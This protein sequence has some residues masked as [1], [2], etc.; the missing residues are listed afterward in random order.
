MF[1]EWT[2]RE[3]MKKYTGNED[4]HLHENGKLMY[5]TTS[6]LSHY[7][8]DLSLDDNTDE[9]IGNIVDL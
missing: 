4:G 3:E 7:I 9:S 2:R 8:P 1:E 6:M 5:A